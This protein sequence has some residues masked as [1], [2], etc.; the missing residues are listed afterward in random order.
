MLETPIYQLYLDHARLCFLFTV[1]PAAE[2]VP[3]THRCVRV[4]IERSGCVLQP[5]SLHQGSVA[6]VSGDE[7]GVA[8][9]RSAPCVIRFRI[10]ESGYVIRLISAAREWMRWQTVK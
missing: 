9:Y 3:G 7:S 10:R 5:V 8:I 2:D 6:A 4:Y 1:L